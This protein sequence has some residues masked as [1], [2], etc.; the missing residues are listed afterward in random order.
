MPACCIIAPASRS[1]TWDDGDGGLHPHGD[2]PAQAD[3]DIAVH[4]GRPRKNCRG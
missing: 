3:D 4:L 1:D 2:W